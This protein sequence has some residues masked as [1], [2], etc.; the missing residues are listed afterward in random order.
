[1]L[2]RFMKV[3][4]CPVS[5]RFRIVA[6]TP[7]ARRACS[8]PLPGGGDNAACRQQLKFQCPP[9]P[10]AVEPDPV[11][12]AAGTFR[13]GTFQPLTTTTGAVIPFAA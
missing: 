13:T 10:I 11:A 1:M 6:A 7:K 9:A 3:R 4:S 2:A 12:P 8:P 5:S